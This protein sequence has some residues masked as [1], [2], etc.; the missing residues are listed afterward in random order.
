[1]LLDSEELV[2]H[3]RLFELLQRLV[4]FVFL[5]YEPV[6]YQVYLCNEVLHPGVLAQL[7]PIKEV[8]DS[9]QQ[10]LM[11]LLLES[12]EKVE[13]LIGVYQLHGSL[14]HVIVEQ[15]N[16][17]VQFHVDLRHLRL[18]LCCL[19]FVNLPW[20]FRQS[21]LFVLPLLEVCIALF[22]ALLGLGVYLCYVL[23]HVLIEQCVML[24]EKADQTFVNL[25]RL[26]QLVAFHN[27][28]QRVDFPQVNSTLAQGIIFFLVLLP[29]RSHL[30][31][32]PRV[33]NIGAH[34][35]EHEVRL[36]EDC[37]VR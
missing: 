12:G 4:Q 18:D 2:L 9:P 36:V 3:A 13:F 10:K 23:T 21:F 28:P 6:L 30:D 22:V 31:H 27:F 25:L 24:N 17:A 32:W 26:V 35:V 20:H 14:Q 11:Q 37:D 16:F 33:Y 19:V 1:M 34:C 29:N 5:L 8:G 7:L 15:Y